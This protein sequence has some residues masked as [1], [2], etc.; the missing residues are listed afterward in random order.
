MILSLLRRILISKSVLD[1]FSLVGCSVSAS[2]VREI[3]VSAFAKFIFLIFVA[4]FVSP[5]PEG[6]VRSRR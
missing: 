6:A 1:L 5:S 4:Q 2:L 3:S